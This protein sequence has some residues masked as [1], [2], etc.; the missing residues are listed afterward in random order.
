[1][2]ALRR[3]PALR[4]ASSFTVT[5]RSVLST[6]GKE[7]RVTTSERLLPYR[8][9]RLATSSMLECGFDPANRASHIRSPRPRP[10]PSSQGERNYSVARSSLERRSRVACGP[11][12]RRT[13]QVIDQR[14]VRPA[15]ANDTSTTGTHVSFIDPPVRSPCEE[16]CGCMARF[17]TPH[18]LRMKSVRALRRGRFL[19]ATST[20]HFIL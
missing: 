5:T 11:A 16:S 1:M 7:R 12:S 19:P 20:E 8:A 2:S 4:R 17:T 9:R 14:C 3:R 10:P 13:Q 18:A 6:P 15:S